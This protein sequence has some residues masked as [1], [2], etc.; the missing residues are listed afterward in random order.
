MARGRGGAAAA[1]AAAA[2]A[3][4]LALW[5]G[6]ARGSARTRLP[7]MSSAKGMEAPDAAP[8]WA[9]VW[10]ETHEWAFCADAVVM[11]ERGVLDNLHAA[12]LYWAERRWA[13]QS[14]HPPDA[15]RW[16]QKVLE[17]VKGAG[18]VED[19]G[20]T[21]GKFSL[22]WPRHLYHKHRMVFRCQDVCD[23]CAL[24]DIPYNARE[25]HHE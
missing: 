24:L 10:N 16:S 20:E 5:P 12:S 4:G 22:Q 6:R 18:L 8:T 17:Q 25:I 13:A 1:A 14:G 2:A 9:R 15:R 11:R 23:S 21:R 19:A 3:L 7:G